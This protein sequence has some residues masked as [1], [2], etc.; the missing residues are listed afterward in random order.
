ML[1]VFAIDDF[2][3]KNMHSNKFT[4]PVHIVKIHSYKKNNE[5][6]PRWSSSCIA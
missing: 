6:G 3:T 2:P 1:Q 5:I 4:K